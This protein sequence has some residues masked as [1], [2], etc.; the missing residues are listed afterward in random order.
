MKIQHVN[1]DSVLI[2]LSQSN[3]NTLLTALKL[4]ISEQ[5]K[6]AE[7]VKLF[8]PEQVERGCQTVADLKFEFEGCLNRMDHERRKQL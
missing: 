6:Y 3:V 2:T 1:K 7:V 4:L 5:S 8:D